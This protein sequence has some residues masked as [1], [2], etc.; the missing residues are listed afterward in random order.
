VGLTIVGP[1][2]SEISSEDKIE[3]FIVQPGNGRMF[4]FESGFKQER[5]VGSLLKPHD[6]LLGR[7]LNGRMRLSLEGAVGEIDYLTLETDV[8][9]YWNL[10]KWYTLAARV[11]GAMSYGNTPQTM[12]LGGAQSVRGYEY[13]ELVGNHALL[14]N[15]EFRFPL[16]RHLALG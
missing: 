13:G 14:A 9:K 16:V 1:L 10:E 3:L 15:V 4:L 11:Y 6:D 12:Y 8:R 2:S 7:D 5:I